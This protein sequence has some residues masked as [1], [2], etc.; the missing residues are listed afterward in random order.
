VKCEYAAGVA[1]VA[2]RVIRLLERA[3]HERCIRRPAVAAPLGLARDH[4]TRLRDELGSLGGRE[5]LGQRRRRQIERGEPL[6]QHGHPLRVGALVH[7]I[8]GHR[9]PTVAE[10]GD[11]LVGEDHQLL[12]QAVGL[13]LGHGAR[14]DHRA[15]GV[16]LELRLGGRHLKRAART[17]L[18]QP[19]G[20]R[21]RCLERLGYRLGR[22]LVAREEAVEL[23]VVEPC[24]RA[25]QAAVEARRART[26]VRGEDDL[27]GDDESLRARGEAAGVVRERRRQHRLDGPGDVGAVGASQRLR[28]ERRARTN[29]SADV[30]DM[31]PEANLVALSAGRD[32]VVE[33]VGARRVDREGREAAEVAPAVIG[34]SGVGGSAIR[35]RRER[36]VEAALEA[37]LDDQGRGHVGGP[38]GAAESAQRSGT[39]GVPFGEHHVAGPNPDR[40]TGETGLRPALEQRL[41]DEESPAPADHP[42]EGFRG[43]PPAHGARVGAPPEPV[44]R[45]PRVT[46]SGPGPAGLGRAPRRPAA[47]P[48]RR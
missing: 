26:A 7:A 33:I 45:G 18:G 11:P 41:A 20:R 30:G 1:D 13:G 19:G 28:L 22:A 8:Q 2:V 40:A 10:L 47:S 38:F 23:V 9:A 37:S 3:Q 48:G 25:D 29:V 44:G 43:R 32:R 5:A 12:D 4:P 15:V 31:D 35:G 21:A 46:A 14:P 27:R 39:A 24:V 17:V 34:L 42:D 36:S 6:E 16:E